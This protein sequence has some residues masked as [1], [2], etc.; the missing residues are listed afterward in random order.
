MITLRYDLATG[1]WQ[2]AEGKTGTDWRPSLTFGEKPQYQITVDGLPTG[3]AGA[4]KWQVAVARDWQSTTSPMCR[5]TEG[6]TCA[7]SETTATFSFGI[8]TATDRFLRV[9]DG[10]GEGVPCSMQIVG[11]DGDSTPCCFVTMPLDCRPALDP[12]GAGVLPP[13]TVSTLTVAEIEGMIDDAIQSAQGIVR[14]N[15]VTLA[16]ASGTVEPGKVYSIDMTEDFELSAVSLGSDYG[17]CVVFV[18]PNE[19]VFSVAEGMELDAEMDT[20][21]AYRLLVSWTPLGILCEQTGQWL[22]D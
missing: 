8:D 15:V 3:I 19:F 16:G 18:K 10:H 4:S 20:I 9:V 14:Q 12:V 6:V 11:L 2:N 13:I 7:I 22:Q 1:T 5:T 21:H 17:E